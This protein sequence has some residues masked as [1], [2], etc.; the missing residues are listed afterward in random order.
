MESQMADDRA[1]FTGLT[2]AQWEAGYAWLRD[3]IINWE[4]WDD[5]HSTLVLHQPTQE[6]LEE[7]TAV[8]EAAG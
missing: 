6:Q 1:V 2:E 5:D 8:V 7:F 3:A 4:F